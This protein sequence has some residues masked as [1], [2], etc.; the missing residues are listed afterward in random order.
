MTE[1]TPAELRAAA[2][3]LRSLNVVNKYPDDTPWGADELE[4]EADARETAYRTIEDLARDIHRAGN[5]DDGATQYLA[6]HLVALG[7]HK[8]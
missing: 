6:R 4:N 5:A 1:P 2:K 8:Q 7:W 3:I